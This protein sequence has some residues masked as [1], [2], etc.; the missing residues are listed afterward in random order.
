MPITKHL[1]YAF[2]LTHASARTFKGYNMVWFTVQE[3]KD[4]GSN[5]ICIQPAL[6][7]VLQSYAQL[8]AH[9]DPD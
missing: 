3:T 8:I 5:F 7:D 2:K 6:R 1:Q 9:L 4:K